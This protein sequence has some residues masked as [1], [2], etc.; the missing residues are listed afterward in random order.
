M[1]RPK[2][3]QTSCPK[4]TQPKGDGLVSEGERDRGRYPQ[5]CA[6]GK[7]DEDVAKRSRALGLVA[8]GRP[9]NEP[10]QHEP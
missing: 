6:A 8:A 10:R 7:L 9:C 2:H 1:V 5:G 4:E 3:E